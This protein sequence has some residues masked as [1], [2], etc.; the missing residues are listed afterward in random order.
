M[1][2]DQVTKLFRAAQADDDLREK[3]NTARDVETLVK[4]AQES[5]YD[6]TVK[7]WNEVTG[8]SVEELP[9]KISDIPGI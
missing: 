4:L 6:F 5:G 2:K 3:L 7:E 8:F 9:S 1:A